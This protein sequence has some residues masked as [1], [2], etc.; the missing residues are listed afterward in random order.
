MFVVGGLMLYGFI[1]IINEERV[2]K[3]KST[4]GCFSIIIISILVIVFWVLT[5]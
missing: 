2:E 5:S 3:G 1:K 4:L